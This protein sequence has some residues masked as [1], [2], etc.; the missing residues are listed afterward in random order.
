[1]FRGITY[2]IPC[3]GGKQ[4]HAAPARDL[5]TGSMFRHT[6]TNAERS[7][8]LDTAEGLGPARVLILSALHGL[9]ELDTVL[10]PY[11]VTIGDPGAVTAE[12]VREQARALG[13][14]WSDDEADETLPGGVYAML[15][16]K[17]LAL[18]DAALRP[19]DV[20]AQ[21][22]YEG[23]GGILQQKR[24]NVH[25]GQPTMEP[26]PEPAGPGP[27][28]WIGADVAG[29]WWG[30]PILVSYGRL[31]DARELPAASAP[32]VLDS[33]G[34]TELHQHGTWTISPEQYAADVD[35]Y[36]D[37]IGR[38]EWVAPQDWPAGAALLARTGLTVHEH[39]VRT[40]DSVKLLRKLV[41]RTRVIAV[42]TGEH[43][44][45]Y[46]RHK[47]MYLA[48]GIDL[49]AED[50]VV[51]V[52]ALVGR[53]PSEAAAIIRALHAAGLHR[54]HGFGVKGLILDE[55]GPLLESIDSA[56]WSGE[57]RRRHGKCPHGLVEWERNCPLF[58]QEWGA[59]QRERGAHVHVQQML[60]L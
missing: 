57:A 19:I 2:V 20:Y 46:L 39:Q 13:I 31:R 29:F 1:M 3:G 18:L 7:A 43:L 26:A 51:G 37:Q 33:R 30:V 4:P 8:A 32:W 11:D 35:R 59:Q 25:V 9:V 24:V 47:D 45:D 54:L 58:A 23:T 15:P 52:G 12:R 44:D 14:G 10:E 53:K 38:L 40:I 48:A 50:V 34:F 22:V 6:L 49:T 5:Y 27:K 56:G 60:P 21:D 28:V 41:T 42:V 55:V 16:K 36:A 17:Y